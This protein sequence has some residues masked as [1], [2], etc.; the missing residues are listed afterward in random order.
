MKNAFKTG[1]L[2]LTIAISVAACKG[3]NSTH[4]PDSTRADDTTNVDSTIGKNGSAAGIDSG[5]DNSGSGGTD[6]VAPPSKKDQ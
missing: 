6:T 5:Y 2:A 4:V 1:I 3:N